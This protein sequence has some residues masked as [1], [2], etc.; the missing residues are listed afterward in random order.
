[1]RAL[2][3]VHHHP[4]VAMAKARRCATSNH[5]PRPTKVSK[6]QIKQ[7]VDHATLLCQNFENTIEC[8]S[9]WEVAEELTYAYYAQ[10]ENLKQAVRDEE[11]FEDPRACRE[12]DV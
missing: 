6:N 4:V 2:G 3:V 11:C 1:M 12:Y 9:A 10:Q 5:R 7:A 8:L